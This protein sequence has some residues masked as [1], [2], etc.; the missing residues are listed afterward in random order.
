MNQNQ[1]EWTDDRV[2]IL[3][4]LWAEGLTARQIATELGGRVSRCAVIGKA[5]R[6]KLSSRN[7]AEALRVSNGVREQA[8]RIRAIQAAKATARP[9]ERKRLEPF[10]TDLEPETVATSVTFA[11]LAD[12]HCHWPVSGVGTSIRFCGARVAGT[13]YCEHH[14]RMAYR[15]PSRPQ[16]RAELE[17]QA[18]KMAKARTAKVE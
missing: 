5:R 14:C 10:L 7:R 4:K 3:K 6:I 9:P 13:A 16:T 11:E 8:R 15:P 1:F 12:H 2:E 18:R 17:L